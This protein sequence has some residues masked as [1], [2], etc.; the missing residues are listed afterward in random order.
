MKIFGYSYNNPDSLLELSEC[1]LDCNLKEIEEVI[2]FLLNFKNK[3]EKGIQKG[4]WDDDEEVIVHEHFCIDRNHQ[5]SD[6]I[7]VTRINN[8]N[9]GLA[10][11]ETRMG[12]YDENQSGD[13]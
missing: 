11:K 3:V 8:S 10:S 12:T 6:F 7:I 13:G 2:E 1:S 4:I 5:K 9:K